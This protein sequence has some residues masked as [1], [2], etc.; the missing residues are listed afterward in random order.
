MEALEQSIVSLSLAAGES[1]SSKTTSKAQAAP[2][3][4]R[5]DSIEAKE[6]TSAVP[7]P[8]SFH[9]LQ[10]SW[11]MWLFTRDVSKSWEE[12]QHAILTFKYVEEFWGLYHNIALPSDLPRGCEYSLFKEGI[13]PNWEDERNKKG[14]RWYLHVDKKVMLGSPGNKQPAMDLYWLELLMCL[15]GEGWGSSEHASVVNG[16][17]ISRRKEHNNKLAVWLDDCENVQAA[18]TIGLKIKSSL[19]LGSK[20]NIRFDAHQDWIDGEEN[21]HGSVRHMFKI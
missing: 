19:G 5:G 16:A 14:G 4:A 7:K 2:T 13:K 15:I 20:A 9:P 1:S 6:T 8:L 21:G 10:N 11:T 12:N 17:V 18:V 3:F